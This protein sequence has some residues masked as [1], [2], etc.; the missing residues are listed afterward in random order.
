MVL[1]PGARGEERGG[2]AVVTIA[3][4]PS[5]RPR[6]GGSAPRFPVGFVTGSVDGGGCWRW[7]WG[8]ASPSVPEPGSGSSSRP[9]RLLVKP[10]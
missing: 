8:S 10:A 1:A 4:L 5:G 2:A 6:R 9:A 3:R 7:P